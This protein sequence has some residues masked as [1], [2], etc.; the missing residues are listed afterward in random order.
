[1]K[2]TEILSEYEIKT[3]LE[4]E[5]KMEA[6]EELIDLLI[7]E[8]EISLRNRDYIIEVVFQREGSISTGVGGGVAIPHGTV[9]CIDEVVGAM[10]ISSK[11]IDFDSFDGEPV[12]IVLLLL[13]PKTK[14]GKHIKTMAQVA[15]IFN[16]KNTCDI[17]RSAKS[18]E[19]VIR[20]LEK[21][22]REHEQ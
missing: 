19:K 12:Y 20:I 9:E 2:L 8:H 11:G 15:R 17:I 7:S 18:P 4:A 14:L 6:I 1:M 10:G 13:V 5:D 21:A 3:D 16:E 22:E